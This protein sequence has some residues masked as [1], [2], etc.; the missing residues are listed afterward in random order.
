MVLTHEDVHIDHIKIKKPYSISDVKTFFE[1]K[2]SEDDTDFLIQSPHGLLPYKPSIYDDGYGYIDLV[3][4]E[5]GMVFLQMM[6]SI[7]KSVLSRIKKSAH[8]GD[9]LSD[10]HM[11]SC[12]LSNRLRLTHTCINQVDVFGIDGKKIDKDIAE[13]QKD[14]KHACIFQ[15][16][17][18]MIRTTKCSLVCKLIQVQV[19]SISQVQLSLHVEKYRKMF[20]MGVPL[21][22]IEQGLMIEGFSIEESKDIVSKIKEKE[23]EE[24]KTAPLQSVAI[25]EV[26]GP[27][28]VYYRMMKMGV[29]KEAIKQKMQMDGLDMDTISKFAGE[30]PIRASPS[31]SPPPPPPP[32]PPPMFAPIVTLPDPAAFLADIKSGNFQLR[33]AKAVDTIKTRILKSVDTRLGVPTLNDILTAKSKLKSLNNNKNDCS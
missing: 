4:N 12:I 11:Q 8:Y 2:Y 22:A 14:N 31:P 29:P 25:S 16:T 27:L 13:L 28:G 21:N 33:K 19:L 3:F 18:F 9:M 7:E 6:E 24:K 20:K 23:G 30:I 15:I 10:K 32:P 1:I 26:S 5:S 17:G